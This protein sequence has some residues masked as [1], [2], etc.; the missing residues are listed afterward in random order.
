MQIT[1]AYLEPNKTFTME[2]FHT[3]IEN[4]FRKKLHHEFSTVF[5]ISL[6]IR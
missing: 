6:L 2:F 3:K 1:K 5:Q 4:Y